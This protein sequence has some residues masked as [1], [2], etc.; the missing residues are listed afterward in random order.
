[1]AKGQE[2]KG[3]SG[4]SFL[5]RGE[6]AT[7]AL[8]RRMAELLRPGD[9]VLL[10]GE[11]GSGKTSFARGIA[12]GLGVRER[13]TSPTFTLLREYEGRLPLYHLDAYRLEGPW[14][15]YDLGLEEYL[16]GRGVLVVEWADRARGFFTGERLEVS[17]DFAE[18]GE[19]RHVVMRPHGGSWVERLALLSGE[20]S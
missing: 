19:A 9:V 17:L 11:L 1:M 6:E 7:L 15:L 14:D 10:E 12:E 5:L 18:G 13:V 3:E 8:A 2:E 20:A 16:E 4:L